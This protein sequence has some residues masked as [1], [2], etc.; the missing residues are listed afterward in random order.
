[1]YCSFKAFSLARHGAWILS[2]AES[3]AFS[4]LTEEEAKTA[5]PQGVL[6]QTELSPTGR[7]QVPAPQAFVERVLCVKHRARDREYK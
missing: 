2:L 4:N 3:E 6:A 5:Q 1:M 7:V